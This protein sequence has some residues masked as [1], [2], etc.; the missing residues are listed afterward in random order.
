MRVSLWVSGE[1][2]EEGEG[3]YALRRYSSVDILLLAVSCMFWWRV[4]SSLCGAPMPLTTLAGGPS[5][6]GPAEE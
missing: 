1:R 5:C 6:P 4:P 3:A 2:G